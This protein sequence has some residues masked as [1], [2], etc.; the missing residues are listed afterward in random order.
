MRM[1]TLQT[2]LDE[3][4]G[5]SAALAAHLGV[6]RSRVSQMTT[7]GVPPKFMFAIRDF[8][9]GSVPLESLVAARTPDTEVPDAAPVVAEKQGA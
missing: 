7:D 2:W 4:R 9:E 3:E 6:S 1:K 5:R 8:T